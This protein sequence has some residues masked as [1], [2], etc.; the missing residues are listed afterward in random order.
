M[1]LFFSCNDFEVI[2]EKCKGCD[3]I[4][5]RI[6]NGDQICSYSMHPEREW[7][8]AHIYPCPRATHIK[9]EE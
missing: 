7:F 9:R 6:T 5:T 8:W 3:Y 1:F 4:T 2:V